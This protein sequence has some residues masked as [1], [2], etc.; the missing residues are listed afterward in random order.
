MRESRVP[1]PRREGAKPI[2]MPGLASYELVSVE[3][4]R[5]AAAML[6]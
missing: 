2:G 5:D 3:A 1:T 4:A 6:C